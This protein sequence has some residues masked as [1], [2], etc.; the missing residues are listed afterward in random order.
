MNGCKNKEGKIFG[1]ESE[2]LE[3]WVE[4]FKGLLNNNNTKVKRKNGSER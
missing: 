3:R 1:E 4:Y 2:I